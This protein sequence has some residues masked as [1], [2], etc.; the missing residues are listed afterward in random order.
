M[1]TYAFC[2]TPLT[3]LKLPH[4]MVGD[5]QTVEA[6]QL[7]AL[8]EPAILLDSLQQD[9]ALLV[10][11]VLAHDRVIRNLFLQTT[12][13]PLRFGTSFSS[14]DGLQAHLNAQQQTYLSKLA[15]LEGKAEYTLKLM[16]LDLPATGIAPETTGKDYFLAKKRQYQTQ[17]LH[18][19]QQQAALERIRQVIAQ[20]AS[21][22]CFSGDQADS[23]TAFLLLERDREPQLRQVVHTLQKQHPEWQIT[24]ED[25]LPPYHFVEDTS[26]SDLHHL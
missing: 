19:Q 1:Y 26:E 25:A 23:K 14:L 21:S 10:Q 2:K 6:G 11:A 9:D 17:Q 8:I 22:Y 24:L 13:L 15:Q 18:R 4:G 5:I 20:V 16:P 12:I 7:M 3:P